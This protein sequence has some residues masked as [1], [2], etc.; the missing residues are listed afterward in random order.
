MPVRPA[1]HRLQPLECLCHPLCACMQISKLSEEKRGLA[2]RIDELE[3]QLKKRDDENARLRRE[4]DQ[5][6]DEVRRL[7][8]ALCSRAADDATCGTSCAL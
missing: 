7:S 1:Q 5:L 6:R 8:V 2:D 4:N 3:R